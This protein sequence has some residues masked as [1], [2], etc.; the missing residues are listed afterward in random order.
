MTEFSHRQTLAAMLAA[1]A[2]IAAPPARAASLTVARLSFLHINDVYRIDEDTDGRGG[3][4]RYA[5]AV[6]TERERARAQ[7]R[8]LICVHAGDTLSPSLRSSFD[9]G[10]HMVDLFNEAGLNIF[11]PGNHEF[12]FGK[13][14]YFKRMK[15]ARFTI[16]AANLK[17]SDGATPPLHRVSLALEADRLQLAVIGAAY[18]AT[19]TVSKSWQPTILA[20]DSGGCRQCQSGARGRCGL[21][22]R[23]G[24]RGQ[25]SPRR[26]HEYARRRS[27]SFRP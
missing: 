1:S 6:K 8:H 24:A 26:A 15:E 13:E 22:R 12:D 20:G 3:M 10:A 23:D 14:V 17:D 25:T 19:P 5:A 7:N 18:E 21:Y 2:N 16:L 27:H 4:A 11:V 9:H